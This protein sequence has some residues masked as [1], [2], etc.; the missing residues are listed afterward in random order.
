MSWLDDEVEKY[1]REAHKPVGRGHFKNLVLGQMIEVNSADWA[2]AI[3]IHNP[4]FPGL[5][6][7]GYDS[8]TVRGYVQE[9]EETSDNLKFTLKKDASPID[10]SFIAGTH[11]QKKIK[12]LNDHLD[13]I[14]VIYIW[15]R[16]ANHKDPTTGEVKVFTI[17]QMVGARP[18]GSLIETTNLA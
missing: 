9:I 3:V 13:E 7:P 16:L 14:Q 17:I 5:G 4:G 12:H 10:F 1:E 8:Y 11:V 18:D 6:R 15:K 2:D